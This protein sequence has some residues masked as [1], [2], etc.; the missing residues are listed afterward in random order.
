MPNTIKIID[1]SKS[2]FRVSIGP[3]TTDFFEKLTALNANE[4]DVLLKEAVEVLSNCTNPTA[5]SG[6]QTGI[7]IGYVQSGKTMSFTALTALA[8]DNGFRVVVYLT[9]IKVNLLDQTTKRLKKD[10]RTEADNSRLYKVYQNPTLKDGS[11]RVIPNALGLNH[12]PTILI[13]ILK[14]HKHINE[15]AKLFQS[16]EMREALKGGVLIIDDEAD[17]ASLNTYAR[18]NSKSEDWEDD[19]F[20]STYSSVLNLR[21]ALLN[22]TYIQYTATPQ[23]PLLINLMDLLSPK[24]HVVLTPGEKYTGGR[25]FF[26]DNPDLIITIPDTEVYHHKYNKLS[27]PPQSLM[28]AMQIF[29]MGVAVF[30]NIEAKERLLSMMIHAD[31]ETDAS[32]KFLGWADSL[33]VSW[34]K[35]LSLN[36]G[37][38]SKTELL[39]EFEKNYSEVSHRLKNPPEFSQVISE[40]SQVIR[41]T[42]LKLVIANE[43]EIT[44]G[45][46]SA[47]ILV[48]ADMLNRGFTIEGLM[49]SYMPRYTAGK[50]NADTIQQ[51]CRFFGYKQ[52]YIDGCRVYLK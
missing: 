43:K 30:V 8:A 40:V 26:V 2:G 1:S 33:L 28:D 47:L 3:R 23:A 18:K 16:T 13:T 32:R 34:T 45:N 6:S 51:R 52:N 27:E 50:P 31:R 14:H 19:E 10:L 17:Q 42:N 29:L 22:H 9:G 35:R 4:K 48:G 46:C 11:N 20:S 12:K 37:D 44:W 38:P 7:A 39:S 49:V 41:D 21:A 25:T 15:L 36:D 24:F 5:E